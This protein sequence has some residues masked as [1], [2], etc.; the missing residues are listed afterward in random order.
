MR[1]NGIG[2]DEVAWIERDQFVYY[3]TVAFMLGDPSDWPSFRRDMLGAL[4]AAGLQP[5]WMITSRLCAIE[6]VRVP[7]Q[8]QE[9]TLRLLDE[10]RRDTDPASNWEGFLIELW[11]RLD[12]T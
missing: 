7:S 4:V 2:L 3:A 8:R 5:R 10:V 6:P 12:N 1:E 9:G 11:A